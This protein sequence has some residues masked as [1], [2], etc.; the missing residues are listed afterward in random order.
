MGCVHTGSSNGLCLHRQF[1]WV[2]FT[3]AVQMG[4]VHTGCSNGLC[5]HRQF[6]WSN[7]TS[8]Q[9]ADIFRGLISSLSLYSCNSL[10]E[11]CSGN[12]ATSTGNEIATGLM[13]GLIRNYDR[14]ISQA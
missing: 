14:G 5:S 4:C 1:K 8:I 13:Q 6:I 7:T 12:I 2:V 10:W 11:I 9:D 3:Q